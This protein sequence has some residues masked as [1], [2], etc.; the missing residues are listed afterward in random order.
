[1]AVMKLVKR[2]IKKSLDPEI[3]GQIPVGIQKSIYEE[4][5]EQACKLLQQGAALEFISK[6]TYLTVP[7]LL[8]MSGELETA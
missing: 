7:E 1:M 4:K 2:L 3:W 6:V 5:K 8:R